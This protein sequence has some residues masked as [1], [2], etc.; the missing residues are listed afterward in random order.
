M[1]SSP[2]P[3][4]NSPALLTRL[5]EALGRGLRTTRSLQEALGVDQRT[6]Q[7]YLQ[8]GAWLGL[9]RT[10]SN[11]LTDLGLEYA[12]AGRRRQTVYRKAV[13]AVPLVN[14]LMVGRE[15]VLPSVDEV[16]RVLSY[17][18]PDLSPTTIR[19]RASAVRSL[20]APAMGRPRPSVQDSIR[21]LDLPFADTPT[22]AA[23][24]LS[25]PKGAEYD[26]DAY[27]AV[28]GALIDHGELGPEHLRAVLDKLGAGTLPIGGYIDLFIRRGD[29]CRFGD[30]LVVSA[31]AVER[32]DLIA[33][34]ASVILSDP[35][36]RA[37]LKS[38]DA[39]SAS[40][41]VR[42]EAVALLPLADRY[43]PWDKRLFGSSVVNSD[44]IQTRDLSEVLLDRSL[45][46][47]PIAQ[48]A[49]HDPVRHVPEPF[50][51][52]WRQAGLLVTLPPSVT[53]LH[54]RVSG[55]NG[56]LKKARTAT[57]HVSMP[58]LA[59]RPIAAHGHILHPAEPLPRSVPDTRSLRL[60]VLMNSP[61]F[62]MVTALLL[63]HRA[64]SDRI[65]VVRRGPRWEVMVSDQSYG[66]L[67]VF[68]DSFARHRGWIP[69]RRV[70]GGVTSGTVIGLLDALGIA[71][72]FDDLTVLDETFFDL[73]RTDA[74]EMEVGG[75]LEPLAMAMGDYLAGI[76]AAG[77]DPDRALG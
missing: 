38:V 62:T 4:A 16:V 70:S 69:S 1:T 66:D 58:G 28:L 19:R 73:L 49:V 46:A 6:V 53:H 2:L 34:T 56:A 22:R 42:A 8:A 37:Y 15:P 75:E 40:S 26:P 5:V 55:V 33:S 63:A 30:R 18:S 32:V 13:W 35:G 43:R 77:I 51:D 31:A 25:V 45:S 48:P 23:P 12:Y 65:Q 3:N 10:G 74:E 11:L 24:G 14:E 47:F 67:L 59:F 29:A 44:G 64:S 57:D 71:T 76:R 20:M 54:M 68:A 60:R 61:Y 27:R 21:Q 72:V 52:L 7:Y 39:A 17:A 9:V 36:Y 50:L 41:S